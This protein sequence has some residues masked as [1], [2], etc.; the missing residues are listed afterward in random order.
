MNRSSLSAAGS[1]YRAK[2][3]ANDVTPAKGDGSDGSISASPAGSGPKYLGCPPVGSSSSSG[4]RYFNP[5]PVVAASAELGPRKLPTAFK[6]PPPLPTIFVPDSLA[7]IGMITFSAGMSD[8]GVSGVTPSALEY[9]AIISWVGFSL[10][11]AN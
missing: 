4:P 1:I 6:T 7:N 8:S 10:G 11:G 9:W 3:S 2:L 5:P